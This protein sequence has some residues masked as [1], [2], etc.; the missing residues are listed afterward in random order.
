M[1]ITIVQN[2]T[3][4]LSI[5]R[6]VLTSAMRES[7]LLEPEAGKLLRH[8]PTGQTFYGGVCTDKER[9]IQEYEEIINPK[10]SI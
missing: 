9:K 2:I 1:K 5:D 6:Q 3:K 4:T 10:A 7:Y 8:K